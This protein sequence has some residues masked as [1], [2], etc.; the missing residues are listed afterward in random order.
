MGWLKSLFRG[1][2]KKGDEPQNIAPPDL[3]AAEQK[4]RDA[5]ASMAYELETFIAIEFGHVPKAYLD[6]L[7]DKIDEAILQTDHSPILVAR[8]EYADFLENVAATIPR[9]KKQVMDHMKEWVEVLS[10]IGAPEG[11][12]RVADHRLEGVDTEL[13]LKGFNLFMER[14]DAL[15]WADDRWRSEFP[16]QAKLEPRD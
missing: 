12:E 6:I 2:P 15:D 16:E 3:V 8:A 9:M 11:V 13:T 7:S 4:G 5:A 10:I 1:S 14:S